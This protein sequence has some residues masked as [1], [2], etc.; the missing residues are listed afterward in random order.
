MRNEATVGGRK[1]DFPADQLSDSFNV[2]VPALTPTS[3]ALEDTMELSRISRRHFLYGSA[4][5]AGS[6]ALASC[7]GG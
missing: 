2:E 5:L 7:Y 6:V 4:V 1:I 3:D